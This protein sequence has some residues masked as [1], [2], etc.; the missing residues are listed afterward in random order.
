MTKSGREKMNVPVSCINSKVGRGRQ[1]NFKH[2]EKRR[3]IDI[4]D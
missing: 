3:R 4:T 1:N 2:I